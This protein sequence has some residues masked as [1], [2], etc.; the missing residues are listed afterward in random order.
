MSK[1]MTTTDLTRW[2]KLSKE[3]KHPTWHS[4]NIAISKYIPPNVSVLD[5]GC[6]NKD[7]K[8]LI[9][10]SCSYTGL[11]CVKH[12]YE[13][14][15]LDFNKTNASDIKLEKLYNYAI[16]SGVLEYINDPNAFIK[17]V[18]ANANNIIISYV[19]AE[20]RAHIPLNNNS[21]WVSGITYNS[22]VKLFFANG[23]KIKTKIKHKIHTIFV[24]EK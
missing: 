1:S 3:K 12:D 21:G 17:F 18:S 2:T 5:I 13:M 16:C 4:R 24:L 22:L 11:D 7:M 20:T 15:V 10:S 23:L 9:H 8:N 14:I 19:L 6:G